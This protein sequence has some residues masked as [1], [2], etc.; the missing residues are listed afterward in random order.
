MNLERFVA[1]SVV[2]MQPETIKSRLLTDK[3]FLS[4]A[5]IRVGTYAGIGEFVHEE[6]VAVLE[7]ARETQ[8]LVTVHTKNGKSVQLERTPQGIKV[9]FSDKNEQAQ[10]ALISDFSLLDPDPAVRINAFSLMQKEYWPALLGSDK[11]STILESRPLAEAELDLLFEVADTCPKHVY[12]AIEQKWRTGSINVL[13]LIPSS[14]PYYECLVGPLS[15]DFE[16][17]QWITQQLLP[18]HRLLLDNDL[19][20]GLA[21]ALPAFLRNDITVNNIT[22]HHSDDDM[23]DALQEIG[24]IDTPFA[25]LGVLQIALPRSSDERFKTLAAAVIERLC[26]PELI[27]R[28]GI[29]TYKLMAPLLAL[30]IRWISVQEDFLRIPPYWRRVASIVH[31]HFLLDILRSKKIDMERFPAWCIDSMTHEMIVA[32]LLDMQKEPMWRPSELTPNSLRC[33][34]LGRLIQIVIGAESNG[35]AVPNIELAYSV[36]SNLGAGVVMTQFCGPLEAHLRRKTFSNSPVIMENHMKEFSNLIACL[37]EKP[38]GDEWE[39]L[40]RKSVV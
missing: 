13:D 10:T 28:D 30:C 21:F 40:D 32:E 24:Q 16:V 22:A 1:L 11:W 39:I 19:V 25:L 35:I 36:I 31:C 15:S 34:V 4:H 2:E 18:Y 14:I 27:G 29:D 7:T 38:Y 6:I 37:K 20:S 9:Y 8:G 33:E 5:N 23:W 3:K 12:K 26:A 17:E